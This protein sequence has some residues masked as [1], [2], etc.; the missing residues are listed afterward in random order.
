MWLHLVSIQHSSC[1]WCCADD[2]WLP[3]ARQDA[4]TSCQH[5]TFL[6]PLMLCGWC[7]VTIDNRWSPDYYAVLELLV[8]G[9]AG[10]WSWTLLNAMPADMTINEPLSLI[11]SYWWIYPINKHNCAYHE[12]P[13]W[14]K[15]IWAANMCFTMVRLFHLGILSSID[16]HC[17]ECRS[18]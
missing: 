15:T 8:L 2:A 9:C 18:P 5:P 11:Y 7:L 6:M 4:V 1:Q 16:L 10:M 14:V 13:C 17:D 12:R 3:W